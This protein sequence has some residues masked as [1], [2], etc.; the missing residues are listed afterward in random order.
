MKIRNIT[1]Y[2]LAKMSGISET[3]LKRLFMGVTTDPRVSTVK[4]IAEALDVNILEI[5]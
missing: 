4:A 1:R 3:Q 5:L 2:K